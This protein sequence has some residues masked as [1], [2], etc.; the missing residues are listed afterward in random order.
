MRLA[1]LAGSDGLRAARG[2]IRLAPYRYKWP[3][4]IRAEAKFEPRV[5]EGVIGQGL[6]LLETR[7]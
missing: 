7:V 5:A 4:T 6:E 1:P 2:A 3:F